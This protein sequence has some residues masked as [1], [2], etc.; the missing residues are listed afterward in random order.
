[1]TPTGT[2]TEQLPADVQRDT[3]WTLGLLAATL[4]A[5][6]MG[7]PV[8][9]IVFLTAPATIT[10]AITALIRSQ[11]VTGMGG[12]RVWLWVAMAVGGISLLGAFGT[13]LLHGPTQRL[14]E[15]METAITESAKRECA[16]QYEEDTAELL[17]RYG[18]PRQSN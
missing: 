5:W 12:M 11:G 3:R 8:L 18:V 2:P 14:E 9:W 4:L 10:F 1:M 15:C 16:A 17:E 13:V 7:P 6:V